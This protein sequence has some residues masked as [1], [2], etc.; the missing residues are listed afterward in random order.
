[1]NI[2]LT[3]QFPIIGIEPTLGMLISRNG[4]ITLC[5]EAVFSPLNSLSSED[6]TQINENFRRAFAQL[7][8]STFYILKLILHKV[9][10]GINWNCKPLKR[11][12]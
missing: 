11:V 9:S 6:Y 10:M 1:M 4:D 5:Y 2:N 8:T 12:I 7:P 3:E